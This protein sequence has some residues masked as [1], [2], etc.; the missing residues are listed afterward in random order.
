[1]VTDI[2]GT[3]PSWRNW[4]VF[5]RIHHRSGIFGLLSD[6]RGSNFVGLGVRLRY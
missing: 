1:M 3:R 6:A 4:S 5:A 2:E